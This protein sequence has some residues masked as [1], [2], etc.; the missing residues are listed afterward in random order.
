MAAIHHDGFAQLGLIQCLFTQG[1]ADG[2]VVWLAATTTKHD[3]AVVV[4]LGA[5]NGN[6][7]LLVDAQEAVGMR[8]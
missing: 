2:V 4:A 5:N 1:Y 7:A 3:V 6:F 8:D